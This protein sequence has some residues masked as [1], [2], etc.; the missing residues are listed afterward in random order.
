[1]RN[2]SINKNIE[3]YSQ[4]KKKIINACQVCIDPF[5]TTLK[6]YWSSWTR[7][8]KDEPELNKKY[9]RIYVLSITISVTGLFDVEKKEWAVIQLKKRQISTEFF[10]NAKKNWKK[11]LPRRFHTAI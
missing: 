6:N 9:V 10:E 7:R 11:Q 5:L 2:N 3:N 8:C 1:M 4:Q